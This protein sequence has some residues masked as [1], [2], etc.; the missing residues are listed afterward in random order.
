M[1][2]VSVKKQRVQP[3]GDTVFAL[4]HIYTYNNIYQVF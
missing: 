4:G 2:L 3:L 1:S